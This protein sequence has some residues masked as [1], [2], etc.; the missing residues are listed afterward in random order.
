VAGEPL[1]CIMGPTASGKTDLAIALAERLDG[2]LVSVDSALVYRGLD[3]GSA[4]PAYP[5]HLVDIGD[6]AEAYSAARFALDA[7]AAIADIR[8]RGRRPILVGGTM[9]YFRALL[10]GLAPLPEADP[11]LRARIEEDAAEHGWPHMHA[12]LAAVD[13]AAAARIHPHHSQRIARASPGQCCR[14]HWR[15]G[16]AR[17][18]TSGSPRGFAPCSTRD[19]SG[20]WRGC[21]HA[22]TCTGGC[23]RS[24]PL[25][26]GNSGS[27]S[28]AP[29]IWP[30]PSG[31]P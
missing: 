20:K 3:I 8:E 31:A 23:R 15:R 13:P 24:A 2:E 7:R 28:M 10:V 14:W 26:I 17:S 19:S 30:R 22:V 5:H 21:A 6:P 18:F 25:A 11:A 9:L 12:Q 29:G 27:T 1:L 16:I 4:K